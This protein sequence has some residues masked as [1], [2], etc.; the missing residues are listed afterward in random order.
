MVCVFRP[1]QE[2]CPVITVEQP[3]EAMGTL[4]SRA[5]ELGAQSFSVAPPL[6]SYPGPLPG[7]HC[8]LDVYTYYYSAIYRTRAG[9]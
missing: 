9:R 6:S 5:R 1:V 4:H 7:I 8:C 2:E 3:P